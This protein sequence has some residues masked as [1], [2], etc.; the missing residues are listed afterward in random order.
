MYILKFIWRPMNFNISIPDWTK[1]L[2]EPSFN[3]ALVAAVY[4]M[5][6]LKYRQKSAVQLTV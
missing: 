4:V 6:F 3:N 2:H 1:Q 5:I